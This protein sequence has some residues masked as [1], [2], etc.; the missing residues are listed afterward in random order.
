M[1]QKWVKLTITATYA[2]R[3]KELEAYLEKSGL[4]KRAE[5]VPL[6]D[7]YGLT[8]SGKGLDALV[9]SKETEVIAA[10]INEI[11]KRSWVFTV[12]NCYRKYGSCGKLFANFH[13]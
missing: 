2:E 6:N 4:A 10:K 9:V 1:Y 11:R 13:N 5:I 3:F 12:K 8:I 7:P